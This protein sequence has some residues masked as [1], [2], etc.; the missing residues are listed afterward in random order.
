MN[1]GESLGVP[2]GHAEAAEGRSRG[3]GPGRAV[4]CVGVGVCGYGAWR[5]VLYMV[6]A[7]HR[8][9]LHGDTCGLS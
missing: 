9:D 5:G 8:L 7:W 3:G 4:V 1:A 2:A 6:W